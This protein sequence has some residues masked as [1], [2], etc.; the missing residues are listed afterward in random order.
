ML[1]ESFVLSVMCGVVLVSVWAVG[2]VTTG[3][4]GLV[5]VRF[6]EDVSPGGLLD[7]VLVLLPVGCVVFELRSGVGVTP[8]SGSV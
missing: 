2:I 4:T 7:P 8:E 3:L 6:C 5:S 1:V